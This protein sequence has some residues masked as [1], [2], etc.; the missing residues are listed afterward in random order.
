LGIKSIINLQKPGEHASCGNPLECSGFTY[1]PNIFMENN[2]YFYNFGWKDYGEATL[3]SLLDMVKVM[4]FA[5]TEG[6]VAVHCHAG[7]GRTGVLIA[8]YLV[9]SLRVRANDAIRFVRLKRPNAVQTRGQILCVQEFEQFILPHSFVFCNKEFVK[10]KKHTEFSLTQYLNRQKF[11]L[12]GY[13][14]RTLK[15]IPKILFVLCE[16]LLHL[17]NC[18]NLSSPYGI[19]YEV[20]DLPFTRS[21]AVA[22]I[23]NDQHAGFLHSSSASTGSPNDSPFASTYLPSSVNHQDM[24]E[25]DDNDVAMPHNVAC[26]SPD[27]P[28]CASGMS[29]L[30]DTCLDAV[31][32]DGI[33]GQTLHDNMCYRELSSQ[34]DLRKAF[35]NE[36]FIPYHVDDV[37]QALL[38]D[39]NMLGDEIRKYIRQYKVDLNHRQSAWTRLQ[40]EKNLYALTGLLY[41][42]LEHLRVPVL[43]R[44]DLSYI[45]ILGKHPEACLKKLD[46]G[47]QY[48]L[49]YL[50]RFLARLQPLSREDLLNLMRRL[51]ASLTQQGVPIHGILR[52]SGKGYHK[53]REGTHQ[54]VMEFASKLFDMIRMMVGSRTAA[55]S[56]FSKS[57]Q[58]ISSDIGSDIEETETLTPT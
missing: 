51:I 38:A 49:E 10:D 33:H 13:E 30:D 9:Y 36:K 3:T 11:M 5:L 56:E 12:H 40:V 1:D 24:D 23:N 7:L 57:K 6:K 46:L 53:L 41:D 42:W 44:D 45:V 39:H 22:R 52:P 37:V 27:M 21:F 58:S 14:A 32:G 18:R 26:I 8:C 47:S 15:F 28:S 55:F 31:L 48:V 20:T 29:G 34:S 4:A 50:F 16:R 43:S 19:R 17:C 25:D 54:K 35:E 2:I